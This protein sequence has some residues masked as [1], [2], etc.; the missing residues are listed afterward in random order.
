MRVISIQIPGTPVPQAR[1]R[2]RVVK[3]K[4]GATFVGQ[5]DPAKSRTWKATVADFAFRAMTCAPFEGPLVVEC[6]FVFPPP[7]SFS[8][9]D[10]ARIAA[11]E[12]LP[13][14]TKPDL[15]NLLKG[16]L[17]GMAGIVFRQDGQVWSYGNS[18]KVYGLKAEVRITVTAPEAAP[19]N[20]RPTAEDLPLLVAGG[21]R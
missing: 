17:D 19:S 14:A 4:S 12:E 1:S 6:V 8:K 5:Y 16:C 18:R 10:L 9:R 21:G 15:D 20:G 13:K 3:L 7:G 2:H 11:G